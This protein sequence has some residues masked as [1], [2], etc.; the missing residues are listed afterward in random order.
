MILAVIL[1]A[2]PLV[3]AAIGAP[4]QKPRPA[5]VSTSTR[6]RWSSAASETAS[7]VSLTIWLVIP[8]RR[9]GRLRVSLATPS[10][11]S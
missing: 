10:E 6:S 7:Y 11:I 8:F 3:L 1:A 9:S 5:P 4:G 2:T